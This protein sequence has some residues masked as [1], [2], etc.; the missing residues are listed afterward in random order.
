[1]LRA[2]SIALA[3][4][5]ALLGTA[6]ANAETHWSVGISA[7]VAGVVVSNS[8]YY[9]DAPAPVYYEPAPPVRYA[10]PV[11][12]A[13]QPVYQVPYRD[14]RGDDSRWEEHREFERAR[15]EHAR[16]E[17]ERREREEHRDG[18]WGRGDDGD[19]HRWHRD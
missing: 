7:P 9:A 18:Y 6:S 16:W 3:A 4:S 10:P 2:I 14:W 15:W 8:G 17:H 13:P 5:A 11:Y 1:M 12:V 19:G